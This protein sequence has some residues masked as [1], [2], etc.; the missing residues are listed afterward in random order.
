MNKKRLKANLLTALGNH[1]Q[2]EAA[3]A[4]NVSPKTL[5]AW[6]CGARTPTAYGLYKFAKFCGVTT[7]S[8]MEG[9][10]IED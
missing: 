1:T 9:V 6:M 7:D 4:I 5:S 3:D 10:D 8:L 2:T